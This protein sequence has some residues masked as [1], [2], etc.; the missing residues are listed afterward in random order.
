MIIFKKSDKQLYLKYK[1]ELQRLYLDTFSS[2]LSAQFI[3]KKEAEKYLNHIF[4]VGYGIFG[5]Y[6][7]Q[8]IAA[9]LVTPPGFDNE[10]PDHLQQKY[11]DEDSLYIAEV[12]VHENYRNQGLGKKLMLFFEENLEPNVQNI[13]L[14]VWKENIPAVKL[15][16]NM[17][18]E[19]C[20]EISQQK[21][22]PDTKEKF[23]MHKN[24]MLKSY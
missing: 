9:L 3:P 12:L 8:L 23:T 24:Y 1:S 2:G 18:F 5:L 15:Y 16:E 7:H 11:A 6:D 13:L 20:G 17:G 19:I 21:L 4:N 10:R 22:R 14:R